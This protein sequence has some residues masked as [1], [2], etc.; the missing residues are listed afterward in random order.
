MNPLVD[1][2]YKI[3]MACTALN[4]GLTTQAEK[5]LRWS[6]HRYFTMADKPNVSCK[7]TDPLCLYT[8]FA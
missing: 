5:Y 3:D 6:R 2:R 8:N 1:I 7:E 4:L